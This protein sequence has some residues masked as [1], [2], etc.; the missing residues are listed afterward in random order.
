MAVNQIQTREHKTAAMMYIARSAHQ[1][2]IAAI[3][4]LALASPAR[5]QEVPNTNG[6]AGA[7]GDAAAWLRAI[8]DPRAAGLARPTAVQYGWQE[9][10]L[11]M[12][13]QLDPATMQGGEY[14][15]GSTPLSEIKFAKLDVNQWCRAARAFGAKEIVFMLAHSGGFCMW[16]SKTT[17]Y[18]IGNTPYHGGKGDVVREFAAACRANGLKAGFYFWLPR[19]T[20]AGKDINT[21]AYTQLDKVQTWDDAR[22]IHQARFH[23]IMDRLGS[24]LVTEIWIDQPLQASLGKDI[25]KRATNAVVQAV[26]CQ[27]PFPTIRWPGTESGTVNYPCWSTLKRQRLETAAPDQFAADASQKQDQD[28]PEGE[29]WA[30]HEADT[31]LHDHYWH[32]LPGALQHRKSLEALMNCY[33]KSVGRN[34]F[35]ILNCAPQSDGSIQPDDMK[36]YEEFGAEIKRRF[37]HPVAAIEQVAGSECLLDLGGAKNIGYVDLWEDYRHGQRIRE[38][39]IEGLVGA[40]WVKLAGGTAVGRRFLWP[41]SNASVR[42][43]RVRITKSVGTPL[44]RKFQVH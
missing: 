9:R 39:A 29:Y 13:V 18:H 21:V 31:Q 35:L 42:Q 19:P 34:C 14:D 27:D 15:N 12:F 23:E 2:F 16:P 26:G 8:D 1:F 36:R 20:S 38:F 24:D 22:R 32:M 25:A 17:D 41:V 30:A 11:A 3:A 43:V 7:R 40:E 28:D 37:G 44:I 4:L 33:E 5:A 10:E 6:M